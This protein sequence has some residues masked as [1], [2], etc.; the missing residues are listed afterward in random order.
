M[1]SEFVADT[2]AMRYAR[3]AGGADDPDALRRSYVTMAANKAYGAPAYRLAAY[4]A[5][6]N[7]AA[8]VYRY[9]YKLRAAKALPAAAEW[10]DAPHGAELPA[11]W[12]M[13]YW[14][15]AAA[16]VDWTAADRRMADVA[17]ALWTNFARHADPAHR[18]GGVSVRWDE[19]Q[20]RS[21]RAMVLDKVPNMSLPDQ[22][23][24]FW[25]RY[26]PRV[27]AV[28][29]QCCPNVTVESAAGPARLRAAPSAPLLVLLALLPCVPTLRP[30]VA[31]FA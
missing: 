5:R 19:F 12:G 8:Y 25:N 7:A 16:A 21:P 23:P 6:R 30:A 24:E 10:M 26:Y 2:L 18:A 31:Y 9:E 1:D 11:V 13:P 20:P 4:V 17:M 15:G 22:E 3:Q 29:F 14:S 28:A 27:L